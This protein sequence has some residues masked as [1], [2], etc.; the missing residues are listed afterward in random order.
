MAVSSF[1]T[2][3]ISRH[4]PL[5][6]RVIFHR[7]EHAIRFFPLPASSILVQVAY[8]TPHIVSVTSDTSAR[9]SQTVKHSPVFTSLESWILAAEDPDGRIVRFYVAEEKHEWSVEGASRDAYWL[10]GA[11]EGQPGTE[12]AG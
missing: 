1:I 3:V 8:S 7:I 12:R 4:Q 10:G 9:D 6:H 11:P 2:A 5:Q